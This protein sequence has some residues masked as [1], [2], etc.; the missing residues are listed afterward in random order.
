MSTSFA[1]C[2]VVLLKIEANVSPS[3]PK[4]TLKTALH[5]ES[6]LWIS[7][8]FF[9]CCSHASQVMSACTEKKWDRRSGEVQIWFTNKVP[10]SFMTFSIFFLR[11]VEGRERCAWIAFTLIHVEVCDVTLKLAFHSFLEFISC[12]SSKGS[13]YSLQIVHF[14]GG[15]YTIS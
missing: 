1:K 5:I 15:T 10:Q 14:V 9:F 2:F 3:S 7:F 12:G 6:L 13:F 4:Y 11:L 8:S